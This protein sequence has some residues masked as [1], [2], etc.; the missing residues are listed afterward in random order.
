VT[1]TPTKMASGTKHQLVVPVDL[2]CFHCKDHLTVE[3][4]NGNSLQNT[5]NNS[6]SHELENLHEDM[7][8]LNKILNMAIRCSVK[9]A[10]LA[11][12]NLIS[13]K[14]DSLH[15][16]TATNPNKEP[17]W[18][19]VVK[20]KKTTLPTQHRAPYNIP[21]IVNRYNLLPPQ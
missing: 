9:D 13:A 21:V 4:D 5:Q 2:L 18:T 12:I 14:I 8:E 7:L 17:L 3:K 16:S 1:R 10:I 15:V 11:E 6:A 20:G 19:E